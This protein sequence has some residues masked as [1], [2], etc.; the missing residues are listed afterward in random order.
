MFI[1]HAKKS[2]SLSLT[3]KK[4]DTV[5]FRISHTTP[6]YGGQVVEV[7]QITLKLFIVDREV[8]IFKSMVTHINGKSCA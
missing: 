3:L 2:Q 5:R 8:R 4:G 7:G 1:E 6:V